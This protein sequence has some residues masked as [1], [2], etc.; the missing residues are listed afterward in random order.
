MP[1]KGFPPA[2]TALKILRGNPGKRPLPKR[3]AKRQIAQQLQQFG[4]T[5]ASRTKI[6]TVGPEEKSG[7]EEFLGSGS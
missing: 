4:M 1:G 6:E 2:P 5:P 3:E 7:L